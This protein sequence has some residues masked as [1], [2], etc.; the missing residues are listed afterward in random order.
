M[1]ITPCI[2]PDGRDIRPSACIT[3]AWWALSP[4]DVMGCLLHIKVAGFTRGEGSAMAF[5]LS[6]GRKS[7]LNIH[8]I[9]QYLPLILRKYYSSLV[10]CATLATW[11]IEDDPSRIIC[12]D[13]HIL[14]PDKNDIMIPVIP[15]FRDLQSCRQKTLKSRD[16]RPQSKSA[17]HR[18]VWCIIWRITMQGPLN[19]KVVDCL[20]YRMYPAVSAIFVP[21]RR[22]LKLIIWQQCCI[23]PN[24]TIFGYVITLYMVVY[25]LCYGVKF[26]SV[27]HHNIFI[28]LNKMTC[29]LKTPVGLRELL[30]M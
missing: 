7:D 11:G 30:Y 5:L 15:V 1:Y 27:H 13:D 2:D 8:K 6:R 26:P 21:I 29:H 16:Q 18:C 17:W 9:V 22:I 3:S 19:K 20:I 25:E 28:L 10:H 14:Y 4:D 23:L 24:L 12:A